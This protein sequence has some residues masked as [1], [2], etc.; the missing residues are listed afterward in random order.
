MGKDHRVTLTRRHAYRTISN[1]IRTI[2]TPGG[3]YT[4]QY[5]KKSRNGP[6]CGD[7]K[8]S[9]PGIKHLDS[10]GFKNAKSKDKT[11]ARAYGGSRC[12]SCV[13]LRILRAFLVEEQ[14]IVKKVLAEKQK[15]SKKSE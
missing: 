6:K 5:I 7:C 15:K 8:I 10:R 11:V 12:H 13:K 2:K 14:K 1:K 9:L 4:S 3:R